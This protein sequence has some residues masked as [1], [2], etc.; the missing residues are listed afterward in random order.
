MSTV[1]ALAL[2]IR[3]CFGMAERVNP[4]RNLTINEKEFDSEYLDAIG[5]MFSV[6]VGL[7]MRKVGDK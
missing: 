1:F 4:F 6:A 2:S 7:A 5:P 3:P